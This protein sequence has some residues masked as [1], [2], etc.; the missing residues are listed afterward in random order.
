MSNEIEIELEEAE[1]KPKK[2]KGRK[3]GVV[4]KIESKN[5][6]PMFKD[7]YHNIIASYLL[8]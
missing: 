1:V 5:G 6:K 7:K 4:K 3:K 2:K 8:G